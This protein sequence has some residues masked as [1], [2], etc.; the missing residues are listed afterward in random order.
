MHKTLQILIKQG[1]AS[2][3]AVYI[4]T[5][6]RIFQHQYLQ[7]TA[8]ERIIEKKIFAIQPCFY[9][10]H[11]PKETPEQ[12]ADHFR[13]PSFKQWLLNNP[14]H[15]LWQDKN[16]TALHVLARIHDLS[17]IQ[18]LAKTGYPLAIKEAASQLSC[19]EF[20]C[21][22]ESS[23]KSN[24]LRNKQKAHRAHP[25]HLQLFTTLCQLGTPVSLEC[26]VHV[27]T[28]KSLLPLLGIVARSYIGQQFPERSN[29]INSLASERASKARE[30]KKT[31]SNILQQSIQNTDK[32]SR[33]AIHK[34]YNKAQLNVIIETISQRIV[35]QLRA[36]Q[37]NTQNNQELTQ[38]VM[39][40][41][42]ALETTSTITKYREINSNLL[43]VTH[44]CIPK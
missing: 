32:E 38:K 11:S 27:A 30:S 12:F 19:L 41:T 7:Q 9:S 42:K 22:M 43:E 1:I 35:A 34:N 39:K 44:L 40:E 23:N 33:Q 24:V 29:L 8:Q 4:E 37:Q 13:N 15:Q 17:G 3:S 16:T 21:Q 31:I 36:E 25:K 10:D 5:M 2:A 18:H 20:M 26:L 28:V 6:Q 14:Q